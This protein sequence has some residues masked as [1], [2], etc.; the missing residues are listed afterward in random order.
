MARARA[1]VDS[2]PVDSVPE[3]WALEGSE[4][5]SRAMAPATMDRSY[6]SPLRIRQALPC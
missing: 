3:G 4:P 2:E 6:R 5:A 1:R